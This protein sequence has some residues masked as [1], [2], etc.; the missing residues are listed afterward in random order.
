M[1]KIQKINYLVHSYNYK[2]QDIVFNA[3]KKKKGLCF[4]K[5]WQCQHF[6]SSNLFEHYFQNYFKRSS[7]L[8]I[9]SHPTLVWVK[10]PFAESLPRHIVFNFIQTSQN[11]KNQ[12]VDH[13][14]A[15]FI[16]TPPVSIVYISIR[17]FCCLLRVKLL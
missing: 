11:A 6:S 1:Y 10:N 12:H 14:A 7:S 17:A 2:I 5:D 8:E 15:L 4:K 13:A 16:D 9:L 3:K